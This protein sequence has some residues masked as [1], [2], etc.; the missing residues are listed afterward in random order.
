MAKKKI[1]LE[2]TTITS[3]PVIE[4]E[5]V[6]IP[7]PKKDT[8]VELKVYLEHLKHYLSTGKYAKAGEEVEKALKVVDKL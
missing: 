2:D 7:E 5:P 6:V 4:P 1:D 8:K 3:E